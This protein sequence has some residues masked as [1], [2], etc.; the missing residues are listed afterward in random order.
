MKQKILF[1]SLIIITL[2][3]CGTDSKKAGKY[4]DTIVAAH[5][6]LA[7]KLDSLMSAVNSQDSAKIVQNYAALLDLTK[8]AE[9]SIINEGVLEDDSVYYQS[10]LILFTNYKKLFQFELDTLV[11]LQSLPATEYSIEDYRHSKKIEDKI[12]LKITENIKQFEKEQEIFAKKF[13][14]EL[15]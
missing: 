10:A 5:V 4:N 12:R 3:S 14:L 2:V 15:K 7:T 13:Q 9:N 8:N 11:Q 1:I 6:E